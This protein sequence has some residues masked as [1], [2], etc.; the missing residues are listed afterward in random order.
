[1]RILVADEHAADRA[2]LTGLLREMGHD[3]ACAAD[4]RAALSAVMTERWDLLLTDIDL[5]GVHGLEVI[6]T[7][8]QIDPGAACL[9]VTA[10]DAVEMAVAAMRAGVADYIRKPIVGQRLHEAL[11]TIEASRAAAPPRR[12]GD[13]PSIDALTGLASFRQLHQTLDG[14]L[15]AGGGVPVALAI[16]DID[17]FHPLNDTVGAEGGDR[18]L[19]QVAQAIAAALGPGDVAGRLSGDDFLVMMPRA[20]AEQGTRTLERIRQEVAAIEFSSVSGVALPISVSCGLGLFPIDEREKAPLLRGV[21][22]ALNQ[23]KRAGG[24][25]IR[26]SG[27]EALPQLSVEGFSALHGL[28]R[29]IDARD[30]YTRLHSEQATRYALRVAESAGMSAAAIREIEVVG[31]LH[32]LGKIVIPDA[33]LR[34]PGPLTLEEAEQMRSHSSIGAII[35]ATLPGFDNMVDVVRHHHER[36]DGHGYPAQL[37][38]SEI[39]LLVRAFSL[40]D[41]FSAMV[42]DRPYRKA[43]SMEVALD[44]IRRGAGSQFDA[45]LAQTFLALDWQESLSLSA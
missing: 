40:G 33:I 21:E 20:S 17:N 15:S 39:P 41:A 16:V 3:A 2:A 22:L 6:E 27:P 42:T 30:R 37:R 12:G 13:C 43:L 14:L 7:L 11:E 5:H 25:T 19:R 26:L 9:V 1:M 45:D 28:V 36:I 10:S 29:A 44:Q 34:K 4:G 32:D 35:A 24:N 8:R 38:G 18:L 23:A 31:P